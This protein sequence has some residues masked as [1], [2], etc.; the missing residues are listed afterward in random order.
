[1]TLKQLR[2]FLAVYS[3]GTFSGAAKEL[4][5]SEQALSKTIISLE[6]ELGP[7]FVRK[8]RSLEKTELG[9]ALYH[10]ASKIVHQFDAFEAHMA[11]IANESRRQVRL[12]VPYCCRDFFL[13]TCIERFQSQHPGLHITVEEDCD[14]PVERR[15][16]SEPFDFGICI[17]EPL[18]DLDTIPL[19]SRKLCLMV[20]TSLPLSARGYI[21]LPY[22][23]PARLIRCAGPDFKI[24]HL[25]RHLYEQAGM[26]ADFLLANDPYSSYN[27]ALK[28]E[29]AAISFADVPEANAYRQ[30]FP[31]PFKNDFPAWEI[32]LARAR[33]SRMKPE[34][35]SLWKYMSAEAAACVPGSFSD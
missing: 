32:R 33:N 15:L 22:D 1:M 18:E 24:Y 17:G 31:V 8:G 35:S 29:I 19:L 27:I 13:D 9:H 20:P 2:Y 7:L 11:K 25:L 30:L 21:C 3:N 6:S 10:E 34:A 5:L 12:L 23:I 26:E 16:L 4:F 14:V 28:E